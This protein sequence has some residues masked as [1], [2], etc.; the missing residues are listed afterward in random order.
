M[1]RD[2]DAARELH[3][4]GSRAALGT[5]ATGSDTETDW[6]ADWPSHCARDRSVA[7]IASSH[8]CAAC[9]DLDQPNAY[10]RKSE[11]DSWKV[12]ATLR[13]DDA[14]RAQHAARCR[15]CKCAAGD[16]TRRCRVESRSGFA[17]DASGSREVCGE[18]EPHQR[19]CYYPPRGIHDAE[20]GFSA[21]GNLASHH[22]GLW[23]ARR[24][25]TRHESVA[26]GGPHGCRDCVWSRRAVSAM[27][28]R[29]ICDANDFRVV[30]R[31]ATCRQQREAER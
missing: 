18:A 17:A 24:A 10:E 3:G 12:S 14:R 4:W 8:C 2:S 19:R 31:V 21:T 9:H 27:R 13:R 29:R 5:R 11:N 20:S 22:S 6:P 30:R 7:G 28:V 16:A 15:H 25:D 1:R 26:R 23:A